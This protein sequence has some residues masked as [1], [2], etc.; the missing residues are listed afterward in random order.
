MVNRVRSSLAAAACILLLASCGTIMHGSTQGISI[1]SNP[2]NARV[3]VNGQPLG[4]TPVTLDLKRKDNHT[5]RLELDGYQPYEV[6]LSR[7]VSGWVAGNIIFGGLIGLAVDAITGGMY[8]LSP[9]QIAGEMRS[10]STGAVIRDGEM[11]IAVVMQPDSEWEK[12]GQLDPL[13]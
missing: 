6:A 7:G 2:T 11:F 4:L 9:E 5:V 10:M 3:L 12:F 8:K 1:S 13:P